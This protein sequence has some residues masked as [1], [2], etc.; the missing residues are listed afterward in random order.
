MPSH[1]SDPEAAGLPLDGIAIID[2]SMA[3]AGPLAVKV[4]GDMG[5]TVVKLEG[6]THYDM[7][8]GPVD[9]EDFRPYAKDWPHGYAF[10]RSAWHHKYNRNKL[11][12][13][14]D[15]KSDA[16]RELFLEMVSQVD[17]IVE[18]F[19][20]RVMESLGLGFETLKEKNP[21]LVMVSMPAFGVTGPEHDYVGF[22][23]AVEML[24]GFV[25]LR[26]YS[27]QMPARSGINFVDPI[28]GLV[29]ATAILAG[30]IEMRRT[31]AGQY[32]DVSQLETGV[33][34]LGDY[35]LDWTVNGR[36]SE[37]NENRS[38]IYAP[39]GAYRCAGDDEWIALTVTND[40]QWKSLVDAFGIAG[41]LGADWSY[42]ERRENHDEIDAVLNAAF[43]DRSVE[44]V[45]DALRKTGVPSAKV[46]KNKD[47]FEDRQLRHRDFFQMVDHPD[48]GPREHPSSPWLTDRR[49]IPI[50][51]RAPQLGEHNKLVLGDWL[52]VSPERLK[53]L[54]DDGLIG[55]YPRVDVWGDRDNRGRVTPKHE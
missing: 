26:G 28:A 48:S 51:R 43:K 25:A 31:G 38:R 2:L 39:Q 34:M 55:D 23:S 7:S 35:F 50:R 21:R 45:L 30:L 24:A 29:G 15:L 20:V 5:A 6:L 3:L 22:G 49:R 27:G 8:R 4:L 47:I 11:D 12:V 32:V 40:E 19:S 13:T 53:Q 41:S 1:F 33:S 46:Y 42:D 54:E 44:D 37:Q 52:G 9:R 14:L 16:G 18:N 10:N 17:V 36:L